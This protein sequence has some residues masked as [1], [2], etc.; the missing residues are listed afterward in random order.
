MED[1]IKMLA[2]APEEQRLQ[3]VTE[4]VKMIAGQPEDQR[5]QSVTGMVTA[6]FKLDDKKIGPFIKTRTKAILGLSPEERMAMMVARAKAGPQLPENVNKGDMKHTMASIMEYPEDKQMAFK[7]GLKKAFEAAGLP[8][9][10]M[11]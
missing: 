6:I 2:D 9:P 3:M 8:M 7:Q 11:P 10:D 5:V 4:R 1:M